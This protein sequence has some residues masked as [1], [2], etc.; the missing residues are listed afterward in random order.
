MTFDWTIVIE[1][2]SFA[3]IAVV[4]A[5]LLPW[6]KERIGAEKLNKLW[7]WICWAVEAAEQIFGAGMGERKK[8]YVQNM[9]EANGWTEDVAEEELDALIEAAVLELTPT[10]AFEKTAAEDAEG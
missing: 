7:K 10:H 6:F 1:I 3:L 4:V 8:K 5:A 9:A 2:A